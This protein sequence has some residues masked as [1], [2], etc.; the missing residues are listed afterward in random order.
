[1]QSENGSS[2]RWSGIIKSLSIP[3]D[4]MEQRLASLEKRLSALEGLRAQPPEQFDLPLEAA[5]NG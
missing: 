4:D 2:M 3:L 1:M 5:S